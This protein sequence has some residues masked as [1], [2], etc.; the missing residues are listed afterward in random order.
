MLASAQLCLVWCQQPG[1]R[2]TWR[3]QQVGECTAIGEAVQGLG[4][5]PPVPPQQKWQQLA[6]ALGHG[7]RRHPQLAAS[8]RVQGAV[9]GAAQD[10]STFSTCSALMMAWAHKEALLSA[11][12]QAASPLCLHKA[13]DHI[14]YLG[15]CSGG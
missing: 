1:M 6:R 7:G 9:P 2:S 8:P 3:K 4:V 14:R 10:P 13:G 12:K 11:C 5:H 15:I